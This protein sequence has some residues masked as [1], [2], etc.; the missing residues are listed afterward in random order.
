MTIGRVVAGGKD[1]GSGFAIATATGLPSRAVLT[2]AHV[3]R[4]QDVSLIQ[5]VIPAGRTIDVERVET[6]EDIDVAVLHLRE[7]VDGSAAARARERLAWHVEAR[8]RANDPRLTGVV[9]D[10]QRRFS[11]A[12]GPEIHVMQLLVDQTVGDYEG[13]SG[14]PVVLRSLEIESPPV[15]GVLIE[16]LRWRTPSRPGEK[17]PASNVLYAIAIE[18]A[19]AR[20]GLDTMWVPSGGGPSD[21]Q[22]ASRYLDAITAVFDERYGATPHIPLSLER[23]ER[24][25]TVVPEALRREQA[26]LRALLKLRLSPHPPESAPDGGQ[27]V[28]DLREFQEHR[29]RV[30]LLGRP[31]AGKSVTL[32]HLL[33]RFGADD[34]TKIPIFADLSEWRD[35]SLGLSGFL[36]SQLRSLGQRALAERLPNLM[37]GGR[38]VLLL[39]GLNEMPQLGR[40]PATARLDDPRVEAIAELGKRPEWSA[41]GCVLSCRPDDFRGGPVWHDVY[42]LD[43]DDDQVAA[44]AEAYFRDLPD[45]SAVTRDFLQDLDPSASSPAGRLGSLV[46]NPFFLVKALAYFSVVRTIPDSLTELLTFTVAEALER[47]RVGDR[48]GELRRRLGCLAFRMTANAQFGPLNAE[49]AA[50]WLTLDGDASVDAVAAAFVWRSAEGAALL[51]R[52][53]DEIR[54]SHQLI[55]EYFTACFLS[56]QPLTAALVETVAQPQ[57]NEIWSQWADLDSLLVDRLVPILGDAETGGRRAAAMILGP[58]RDG[59]AAD[60]LARALADPD[61]TVRWSA[62]VSLGLLA[63]RRAGPVLV[64]RLQAGESGIRQV[65]AQ[66]LGV[67]GHPGAVDPLVDVLLHD[68]S[69]DVRVAAATA[70]GRSADG[71]ALRP[72]VEVLAGPHDGELGR[73]AARALGRLGD[74]RAVPDLIAQLDNSTN[75]YG[76]VDGLLAIGEMALDPLMDVLLHDRNEKRR[77]S[78]AFVLGLSHRPRVIP[79]LIEGLADAEEE[80]REESASGLGHF[81]E[82]ALA[83][84]IDVL[85]DDDED[86]QRWA[87]YALGVMADPR[88]V[89]HLLKALQSDA[90]AVAGQASRSLRLCGDDALE[91]LVA[92]MLDDVDPQTRWH[93]AAALGGLGERGIAA[94]V[95]AAGSDDPEVRMFAVVGLSA[96][97]GQLSFRIFS[98]DDSRVIEPLAAALYDTEP[99]VRRLAALALAE[100]GDARA[101]PSLETM[102]RSEDADLRAAALEGLGHVEDASAV[103]VL[104]TAL[105]DTDVETRR[106]AC[107]AL[108]RLLVSARPIRAIVETAESREALMELL[109]T[110]RTTPAAPALVRALRRAMTPLI[111]VLRDP[112][113]SVVRAATEALNRAAEPLADVSDVPSAGPDDG[114]DGEAARLRSV[115]RETLVPLSD[116]DAVAALIATLDHLNDESDGGWEPV[117]SSIA[118][119][120][121]SV[122][123]RQAVPAMIELLHSSRRDVC[124]AAGSALARLGGPDALPAL[125]GVL[126]GPR[127]DDY[128]AFS[129]MVDILALADERAANLLLDALRDSGPYPGRRIEALLRELG[130]LALVP[131]VAALGDADADFARAAARALDPAE[132]GFLS[133]WHDGAW[134]PAIDALDRLS[135][136]D[137]DS[138]VAAAHGDDEQVA[139]VALALLA[140]LG[141]P[142]AEAASPTA[143]PEPPRSV[144][145]LIAA[146]TSDHEETRAEAAEA[147]GSRGDRSAVGP[148]SARLADDAEEVRAAAALALARLGD[149]SVV[150]RLGS[151]LAEPSWLVARNAA[152]ALG[153]LGGRDALG[154]LLGALNSRSRRGFAAHALTAVDEQSYREFGVAAVVDAL[155]TAVGRERPFNHYSDDYGVYAAA[156]EVLPQLGEPALTLLLPALDDSHDAVRHLAAQVLAAGAD[157]RALPLVEWMAEYDRGEYVSHGGKPKDAARS[158]GQQIH[159]AYRAREPV[160]EAMASKDRLTRYGAAFQLAHRE[161]RGAT[162]TL[163][164]ALQDPDRRIRWGAAHWLGE[165]GDERGIEPLIASL[166]DPDEPVRDNVAEALTRFGRPAVPAVVAALDASNPVARAKASLVLGDVGGANEVPRL[167]VALGD[168]AVA[169]CRAA[170]YA[171]NRLAGQGMTQGVDTD[172]VCAALTTA[173]R[174]AEQH[175]IDDYAHLSIVDALATFDEPRTVDLLIE[176]LGSRHRSVRL[177]AVKRLGKLGDPR[178]IA[179]LNRALSDEEWM[180]REDAADSLKKFADVSSV[181][182]LVEQLYHGRGYP[183][184]AAIEALAA[185]GDAR[186]A[187]PLVPLLHDTMSEVRAEAAD[188]I[189]PLADEAAIELL[190]ADLGEARSDPYDY[191]DDSPREPP[192]VGVLVRIGARAAR[193]LIDAL[194]NGTTGAK[195]SY[196]ASEVLRRIGA[197]AIPALVD[198]LG[199]PKESSRAEMC[200]ERLA[201]LGEPGLSAL[202]T[203]LADKRP[204]VRAGAA[205]GL[206]HAR[207]EQATPLLANALRDPDANVR[208]MAALALGSFRQTWLI[209]PLAAAVDDPEESV[210]VCAAASL[211]LLGDDRAADT[212]YGALTNDDIELACF[213]AWHIGNGDLNGGV[214]PLIRA[215][216][217]GSTELRGACAV[218]LG[219]LG[220]PR[221]LAA[222]DRAVHDASELSDGRTVAAAAAEAAQRIRA[223]TDPPPHDG[224]TEDAPSPVDLR[225]LHDE[226]ETQ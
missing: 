133:H 145:E 170:A 147:L 175:G 1:R 111:A 24:T 143:S 18:D 121:G 161:W 182:P 137:V 127:A 221:A 27:P 44:F 187:A 138:L 58:L 188:T 57:F 149:R 131:L 29:V 163:I 124:T 144:D 70:L 91:Q 63:D 136:I 78:A 23:G 184:L 60:P 14:S 189:V 22:L 196:W 6:D 225:W 179:P 171:L 186:A 214:E 155:L 166:G 224:R 162:T 204:E 100:A 11:K 190:V 107:E 84:L 117:R 141:H 34:S 185:I 119:L 9:D 180:V 207:D 213:A 36:Q 50:A 79:A 208:A 52:S 96:V 169:V 97:V 205:Y 178:A 28:A 31:G 12:K 74:P 134:R 75:R 222:L 109:S 55:Q 118:S 226:E 125:I 108:R 122:G 40:Y 82:S 156:L 98:P 120:L 160:I 154:L 37:R 25:P 202:V 209:D 153:M 176:A 99:V 218:A 167:V 139:P 54:F 203:A 94:L 157:L 220:D 62:A 3:V 64:E 85:D 21:A 30:V 49:T 192:A 195:L 41:V 146:L 114:P 26:K 110:W 73:A 159:G 210:R 15:L 193:A 71:R 66:T 46:A 116:P 8:P 201:D 61:D 151:M 198:G 140:R 59:R 219:D 129:L 72:L 177:T 17:A 83:P 16:Q 7:E 128:A 32:R 4:D 87:L 142:A 172:A 150:D 168:S 13:Y 77:E 95:T 216:Q 132:H 197:E 102:I 43:L 135:D 81:G 158:A 123:D 174:T 53:D 112:E 90:A 212:L 19:L 65:A 39:D 200:A 199:L 106:A 68:E 89:P 115:V 206:W 183:L 215:M 80:V 173:F 191:L 51:I 92:I 38:I 152:I 76:V 35:S 33:D 165:L 223:L 48:A 45:A 69:T 164:E 148:L 103:D 105:R 88:A 47:E 5:F 56:E 101:V 104:V 10:T 181:E 86:A 130:E 211:A 20:F 93:A 2:A 194:A 113:S 126:N 67:L 42:L 217:G